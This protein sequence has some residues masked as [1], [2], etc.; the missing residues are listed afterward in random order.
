MIIISNKQVLANEY[1]SKIESVHSCAYDS[2]VWKNKENK[3]DVKDTETQL[4]SSVNKY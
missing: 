4:L 2:D 1:D 3:I